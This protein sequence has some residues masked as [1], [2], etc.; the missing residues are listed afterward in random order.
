MINK[1]TSN[2]LRIAIVPQKRCLVQTWIGYIT[3]EEFRD[4][5]RKSL[6]I[7]EENKCQYFISDTTNAC[8]LTEEDLDWVTANITPKLMEAG[9]KA[10]DFVV[11]SNVYTKI[12]LEMLEEKDQAVNMIDMNFFGTLESALNSIADY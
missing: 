4:G 5:Q 11:P 7:F 12:T 9:L 8:P 2:Y 10:L 6:E 1:Y 3:S